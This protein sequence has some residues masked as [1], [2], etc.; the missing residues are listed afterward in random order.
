MSI[1]DIE[2]AVGRAGREAEEALSGGLGIGGGWRCGGGT[3]AR[4]A[5]ARAERNAR[6]IRAY[7][8]E[9]AKI[10]AIAARFAMTVPG[11]EKV[12]KQAGVTRGRAVSRDWGQILRAVRAYAAG[13]GTVAEILGRYGI[14]MN[15][16]YD[17][18]RGAGVPLRGTRGN[19]GARVVGDSGLRESPGEGKE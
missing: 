8:E 4:R 2:A 9:G 5:A 14:G 7:E 18:L 13:E 1:D 15:A 16:L 17:G 3:A 6:I 11:V 12:L 10:V 19:G